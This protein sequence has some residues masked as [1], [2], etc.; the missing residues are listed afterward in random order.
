MQKLF[1]ME[2]LLLKVLMK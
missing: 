1:M 2:I